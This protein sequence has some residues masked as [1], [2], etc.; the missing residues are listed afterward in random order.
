[1][2]KINEFLTNLETEFNILN[3][4]LYY[5]TAHLSSLE[6]ISEKE[7]FKV[8]SKRLDFLP[9]IVQKVISGDGAIFAHPLLL[10]KMTG[11]DSFVNE[12]DRMTNEL[13]KKKVEL[14][15]IENKSKYEK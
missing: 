1:M 6:Q 8:M 11:I 7:I 12:T 15:W 2:N 3:K 5:K 14:W 9:F 13:F 10:K 4:E